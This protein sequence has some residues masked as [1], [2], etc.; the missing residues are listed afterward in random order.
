MC[1]SDLAN[2]KIRE[3]TEW[4]PRYT[5]E[6][7]LAETIGWLKENLGHYKVDIYNV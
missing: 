3:L 4:E 2:A 7:G 5:F 6:E 1:S